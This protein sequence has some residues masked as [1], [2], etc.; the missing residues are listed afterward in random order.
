MVGD[1][2]LPLVPIDIPEDERGG[3]SAH[4]A[5]RR[6]GER[7]AEQEREAESGLCRLQLLCENGLGGFIQ[8]VGS[9]DGPQSMWAG[10]WA[11]PRRKSPRP[12]IRS[13]G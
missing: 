13:R 7:G 3:R 2:I 1:A 11:A 9:A 4:N 12:V 10:P 5:E 6:R 8:G